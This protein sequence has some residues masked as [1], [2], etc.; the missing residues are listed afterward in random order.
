MRMIL[1]YAALFL[2]L[3]TAAPSLAG[4]I[5]EQD[6]LN[7]EKEWG[8]AI[9]A[10]GKA[11]QVGGDCRAAAGEAIDRLYAYGLA[12]VLFK[13]TKA[14]DRQF[15]PDRE[16][17]ISYFVGGVASEDHGFALQPWSKVRFGQQKIVVHDCDAIA[18]GNY[19]FTDA[20]TGRE[21]KVEFTFGY[22]R[23]NSGRL[24]I[25]LHHSSLPYGSGH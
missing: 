14:A 8:A 1:S 19:Y 24:R 17:A 20:G 7:A 22:V 5:T 10:I 23:D 11:C 4:P 25:F 2:M 21:S 15:R 16:G 3:C 12:E 18:Q 13:P 6:V 9:V